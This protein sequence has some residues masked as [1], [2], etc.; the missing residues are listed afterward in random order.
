M[1]LSPEY[2]EKF[3]ETAAIEWFRSVEGLP[4]GYHNF[5]FSWIDTPEGNLPELLG[6]DLLPIAFS[7][8]EKF[9]Y[10][11]SNI[12]Y[13]QSLNKKL[14]TVNLTIAE[15]ADEAA[16]RGLNLSEVGAM[17]EKDGW[18]YHGFYHDGESMVCSCY[19]AG[20]WKAAG[21]FD[22]YTDAVEWSP[23]DVYQVAFFDKNYKRPQQCVDADPDSPFCQLRGRFRMT[24]PGFNSIEPYK[25]MNDFC[26]SVAPE[27][28]RPSGC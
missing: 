17:V 11:T 8:F 9:D 13:A 27:F 20:L 15:L 10:N 12:F 5:L 2:R 3:N 22:E 25:N 23:K 6:Q 18:K 7:I 19:V 4:Y 26:P 21:M 16:H 14:G 28:V 24:F 1:P